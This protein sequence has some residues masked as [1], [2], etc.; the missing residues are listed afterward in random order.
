R[1]QRANEESDAAVEKPA[2]QHVH[3][4]ETGRGPQE[5][6]GPGRPPAGSTKIRGAARRVTIQALQVVGKRPIRV[7]PE[8]P[9]QVRG[10]A[11]ELERLVHQFVVIAAAP[12]AEQAQDEV[13]IPAAVADRM[14]EKKAL[15]PQ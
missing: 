3:A 5:K 6:R 7:V 4:E 2:L 1:R 12:G 9:A 8:W 14:A 10:A 13:A 11:F 15:A